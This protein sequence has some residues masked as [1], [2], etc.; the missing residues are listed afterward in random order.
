MKEMRISKSVTTREFRSVES[1]LKDIAKE[2]RLTLEE[3][4][5]L[6]KKI[7]KGDRTALDAL[8][9]GNL[10]FVVSAAKKYQGHGVPLPDLISAG[11]IGLI[12]AA[13]RFD[14]S[15]GFK[16]CTYAVWW[17]RQSIMQAID[18]ESNVVSL[19]ANQAMMLNKARKKSHYMEQ[20]LERQPTRE[21]VAEA[22][23]DEKVP[24]DWLQGGAKHNRSIDTPVG[25]DDSATLADF[26]IDEEAPHPDDR[27]INESQNRLLQEALNLLRPT[28]REAV[29]LFFGIGCDRS[30]SYEEI[31]MRLSLTRERVRQLVRHGIECLRKGPYKKLLRAEAH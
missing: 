31:A 2:R 12:T 11:N 14:A 21:E 29:T 5:E 18:R 22:M 3:E 19:P 1:Y 8:V 26:L 17:I 16:F 13:S 6:S 27:L 24:L 15:R 23:G 28:D 4:V 20:E 30:Y 25:E 9:C 7:Q 10:R